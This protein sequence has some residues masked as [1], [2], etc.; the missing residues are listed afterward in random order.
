MRSDGNAAKR[1]A[2]LSQGPWKAWKIRTRHGRAIRFIET[3]CRPAKGKGHGSPLKLAGFQ[4]E[5]LE[6]ALAAGI[7]AAVLQTPRGNGKSSLGG[8]IATWGVFDDDD[9]GSPQVP[10][11]ATTITQAIRS[12]YGVA[13]SMVRSE[14]ELLKRAL[15]YTGIE[16][17]R[18]VVPCDARAAVHRARHRGPT[19]RGL[20]R[21]RCARWLQGLRPCSMAGRQSGYAGRFPAD[22]SRGDGPGHHAR[23]VVPHLPAR[24]VVREWH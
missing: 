20:P 13:A 1:V 5:F 12:C 15:I 24:S 4:K 10:I 8:A 6:E 14:P 9:T 23:D 2:D 22:V 7:D 3:Y 11:V 17:P 16:Q 21:T 18:I 19:R